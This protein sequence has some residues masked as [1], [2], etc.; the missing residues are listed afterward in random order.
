MKFPFVRGFDP[1]D[2]TNCVTRSPHLLVLL[3]LLALLAVPRGVFAFQSCVE[4]GGLSVCAQ[5]KGTCRIDQVL[6]R[7][8]LPLEVDLVLLKVK[9]TS[10]E[11][12]TISPYDFAG[13]TEEGRKIVLDAPIFDSIEL[14]NKLR[15]KDLARGDELSGMLFFPT[16]FGC[17]RI[18]LHTGKPPFEVLLY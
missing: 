5:L 12:V 6:P 2:S 8:K 4:S 3:L 13:V 14:K 9:N 1:L 7:E 17:V 16:A 10:G 11:I 15:K 18:L